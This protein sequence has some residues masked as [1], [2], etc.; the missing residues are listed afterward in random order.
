MHCRYQCVTFGVNQK[1]SEL[2]STQWRSLRQTES[3]EV[4]Q[5]Q[6]LLEFFIFPPLVYYTW[7]VLLEHIAYL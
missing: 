7:Q 2:K 5:V 1:L 4:K 6:Y 3:T